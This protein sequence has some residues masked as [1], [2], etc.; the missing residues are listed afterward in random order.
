MLGK[1]Q[2]ADS[3]DI[4][5]A[6]PKRDYVPM[7]PILEGQKRKRRNMDDMGFTNKHQKT[8]HLPV[9]TTNMTDD[10]DPTAASSMG[11]NVTAE[12]KHGTIPNDPEP[13]AWTT[14]VMKWDI[15]S[16]MELRKA[17][18]AKIE[19]PLHFKIQ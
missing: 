3:Q 4:D 12:T 13:K 10:N 18:I 1:Q 8:N 5:N 7:G 11:M 14:G 19:N 9:S 17:F 6:T 2:E 16:A 15:E